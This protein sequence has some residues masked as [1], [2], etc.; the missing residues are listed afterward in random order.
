MITTRS[1]LV[2]VSSNNKKSSAGRRF[3][4]VRLLWG[5]AV[6]QGSNQGLNNREHGALNHAILV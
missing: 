6:K 1:G 3:T 4:K 5:W 2:I